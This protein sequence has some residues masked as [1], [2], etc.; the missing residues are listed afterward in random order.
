MKKE[1]FIG[2]IIVGLIALVLFLLHKRKMMLSG[3]SGGCCCK[4]KIAEAIAPP[5]IEEIFIPPTVA[6]AT[7][8]TE[9]EVQ[10]VL[11]DS[12]VLNTMTDKVEVEMNFLEQALYDPKL[13]STLDY[14][15]QLQEASLT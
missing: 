11:V 13:E 10:T 5:V 14:T 15:N 7:P 9:L 2:G 6:T 4:E 3:A 1:Y 8:V 12:Q